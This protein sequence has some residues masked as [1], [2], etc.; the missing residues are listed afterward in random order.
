LLEIESPANS[1]ASR[2]RFDT[3]PSHSE[4]Q[5]VK[6]KGVH[7]NFDIWDSPLNK[8]SPNTAVSATP[9]WTLEP[10]AGSHFGR[11]MSNFSPV[12]RMKLLRQ[13]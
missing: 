5:T 2:E 3:G 9:L 10:V 6:K 4:A 12:R 7:L 1:T 11:S 13:A 8:L